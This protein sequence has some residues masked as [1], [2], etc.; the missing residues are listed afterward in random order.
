[1]NKT[2]LL[3]SGQG[4]Q[5]AG[6]GIELLRY[7]VGKETFQEAGDILGMDIAHLCCNG[8]DADLARTE[9]T[10]PVI[11]TCSIAALRILN[12][13]GAIPIPPA[14][15]AG[16]SVGEYSALVATEAISF[17]DAL[18]LVKERGR[19]MADAAAANPGIML[20]ILGIKDNAVV[21]AICEEA[22][23]PGV[24]SPANYNCPGQVIISGEEKAVQ[25]AAK[26]ALKA[27]AKACRALNVNGA[28]HSV[29]MRS[30]ETGLRKALSSVSFSEPA[31]PFIANVTGDYIEEPGQIR[32]TLALQL[33]SPI[34]WEASM[35]KMID[36][37]VT[38]FFEI[39][40]GKIL[41][42][43]MRRICREVE[44]CSSDRLLVASYQ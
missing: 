13:K 42:G 4:S 26:L 31:I 44:I 7:A 5:Y 15:T 33:S 11:V 10:Q 29:L 22:G 14:A 32:E 37:G 12:E 21:Q 3:F 43:L 30:A 23:S 2:S 34:Q 25:R 24:V 17:A 8:S 16:L 27:G 38:T 41:A 18:R 1:M 36:D 20:A 28:F 35:R 6:M 9:I 19:L 40:P 39:G